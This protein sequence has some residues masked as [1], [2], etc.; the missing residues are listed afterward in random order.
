ME[1]ADFLTSDLQTRKSRAPP[2]WMSVLPGADADEEPCSFIRYQQKRAARSK[3]VWGHT[4][5]P[6][7]NW[8]EKNSARMRAWTIDDQIEFFI[9]PFQRWFKEKEET[10]VDLH[11]ASVAVSAHLR[12]LLRC[13][14]KKVLIA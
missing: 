1:A 8:A 10:Y 12:D 4:E 7:E 5:I 3:P 11:A 13:R 9:L 2:S 6:F 14:Q